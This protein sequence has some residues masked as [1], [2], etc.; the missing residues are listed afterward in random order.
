MVPR[1]LVRALAALAAAVSCGAVSLV[2]TD[3]TAATLAGGSVGQNNGI[4]TNA[5]FWIPN[6]VVVDSAGAFA[7]VSDAGNYV[8]RKL[9]MSTAAVTTLGVG[10]LGGAGCTD[11]VGTSS[12]SF[13][14][15]RGLVLDGVGNL[16]AADAG[17]HSVRAIALSSNTV[18]TLAG[19]PMI[20]TSGTF[21][22]AALVSMVSVQTH[23]STSPLA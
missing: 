13:T 14:S 11:G 3:G 9:D 2:P 17:C 23:R 15:L 1:R 10:F 18:T 4:G 22:L 12:S 20:G 8:I 21:V 6:S 16:Y 19:G 5:Q 7:Y